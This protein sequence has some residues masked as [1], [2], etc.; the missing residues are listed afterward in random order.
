[1]V[2]RAKSEAKKRQIARELENDLMA[3]AVI[4]YKHE[5]KKTPAQRPKGARTICTDFENLCRLETGHSIKLSHTTMIRLANGGRTRTQA[6]AARTWISKEEENVLID[7]IIEVG[8]R[9]FPLSHKRLKEHVDEILCARLGDSFPAEG[10]GHNWTARFVAK[11]SKHIQ[12]GYARPLESKWG[13]AVNPANNEAW[14]QL[15]GETIMK[16]DIKPATTYAADESGFQPAGG[17]RERVMGS[18][19]KGPQYQQHD[20]NRENITIIVTICADGS[21]TP[22]TVIYKGSAFQASWK[23]DN[24]ANAT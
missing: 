2:G 19:K 17:E 20:G 21:A 22:P 12:M 18:R 5:L 7:Y 9:G 10:I 11:H 23:Q 13:Q 16:Y 4:A 24:P 3:R 1:M 14:F 15:L 6:N 8:N